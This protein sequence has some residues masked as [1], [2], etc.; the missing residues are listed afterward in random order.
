MKTN[1]LGSTYIWLGT[2]LKYDSIVYIR[3]YNTKLNSLYT[4]QLFYTE[5]Y[6]GRYIIKCKLDESVCATVVG[7]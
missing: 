2:V 4:K 7:I 5:Y 1:S 3:D 6:I